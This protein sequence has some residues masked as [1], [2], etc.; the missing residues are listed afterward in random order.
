MVDETRIRRLTR[1]QHGVI[2]FG[3]L[4]AA[5]LT[6]GTVRTRVRRGQLH[7]IHR[8]VYAV[9]DP[10]LLPLAGWSAALLAAGPRAVLSHR[11]AAALWRLVPADS[12][13]I[14]VT[15][16]GRNDR[17]HRGVATHRARCLDTRDVTTRANLRVTTPARTVIDLATDAS[18]S[19]VEHAVSEARVFKL[20]T[21]AKLEAALNRLHATH[22]GAAAMRALLRRQVGQVVSRSERERAML[23]LLERAELPRPL[24]NVTVHG[25]QLDFYWP[26]R[27]LV[28]EFDGFGTHGSR[29]A[30]E[31]DRKRDQTLAAAGIQTIRATWLQLEHEPMALVVRIAQALAVRAA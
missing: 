30:F 10:A 3:Q 19:E 1:T 15:R 12:D 25:Y 9:A 18:L 17:V 29:R 5:G 31:R 20:I 28:L 8:G 6:P 21:D 7:R 16:L 4:L 22:P 11:S 26:D 2:S 23:A 14:H 24:V 13:L 27:G